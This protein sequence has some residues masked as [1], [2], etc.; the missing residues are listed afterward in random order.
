MAL[1]AGL[2]AILGQLAP[3]TKRFR[4]GSNGVAG[5]LALLITFLPLTGVAA[6][7][8]WLSALM[9]TRSVRPALALSYLSAVVAEWLFG[10]VNP[11]GPWGL[12]HGPESTLF[13]AV[14]AGALTFRWVAAGADE[15]G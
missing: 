3:A 11:P 1:W 13:V 10:V 15:V 4:G 14:L 7:G 5:S 8:A 9:V 2:A 12:V 6:L